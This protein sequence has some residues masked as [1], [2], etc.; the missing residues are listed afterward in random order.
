MFII[1]SLQNFSNFYKDPAS[2][3]LSTF[4]RIKPDFDLTF[5]IMMAQEPAKV[6]VVLISIIWLLAAWLMRDCERYNVPGTVMGFADALWLTVITF[7]TVGYGDIYPNRYSR[8]LP[9]SSIMMTL[10]YHTRYL[11]KL[12]VYT[13]ADIHNDRIK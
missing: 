7:L 9:L 8:Y 10:L 3:S 13:D 12:R 6:M 11:D 1:P 4:N 5:R 2:Q